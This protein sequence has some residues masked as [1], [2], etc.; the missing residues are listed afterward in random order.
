VRVIGRIRGVREVELRSASESKAEWPGVLGVVA[1]VLAG[2]L[3]VVSFIRLGQEVRGFT[4]RCPFGGVI[5]LTRRIESRFA[6]A[7]QV[8]ELGEQFQIERHDQKANLLLLRIKIESLLRELALKADLPRSVQ[9]GSMTRLAERLEVQGILPHE[10]AA[11]VRDISPTVNRE[12]HTLET[13][14]SPDEY[15]ALQ[16][17]ALNVIAALTTQLNRPVAPPQRTQA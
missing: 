11:A 17:L 3:S 15:D 8:R 4:I 13:Y 14:L 6:T 16:T 12:L 5:D 1:G 9:L 2:I 7:R 10:V